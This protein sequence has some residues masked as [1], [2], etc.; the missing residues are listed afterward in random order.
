MKTKL[1]AMFAIAIMSLAAG[2]RPYQQPVYEPVGANETAFVIP[3]EAGKE[4][5]VKFDSESYLEERKVGA[6]R[7]EIPTRWNTTGY[8]WL[9]GGYIRLA[10]VIKVD[11]T[12][13]TRQWD[14][15]KSNKLALWMESKDSIG[16][17][18]GWSITA[19][20]NEHDTARFLYTYKSDTLSHVLDNE[21]RARIQ[22]VASKIAADYNMDDLR[23][24]KNDLVTAVK[25]DLEPYFKARGITLSTLGQ[26]GGLEY[27]N[28]DIQLAIDK[29][30]IA[31]QV[32]VTNKAM[33]E[34]QADENARVKSKAEAD[35][36]AARSRAHGEA[37]GKLSVFKAE[38][39]GLLAVNK[40]LAEANQ[41]PA[42]VEL[43]RID[44]M[45]LQAERWDGK[46]PSWYMP[47]QNGQSLMLQVTPPTK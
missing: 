8:T 9:S 29:T 22:S 35:A 28:N 36:E 13:V 19:Y 33:L 3:L 21:G 16:F 34:A 32:K 7:I 14:P 47:G 17:S 37:D 40:A 10:M 18:T 42:L 27:E 31:Q 20:I 24:K 2:C 43:K 45:K 46:F 25:A 26:F 44:V 15:G 12:P 5:E 41:N 39:D 4:K 30:F 11:R 6:K 38:A 23:G 1:S